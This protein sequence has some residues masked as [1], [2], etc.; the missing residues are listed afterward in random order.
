LEERAT[1]KMEI[2][3]MKPCIIIFIVSVSC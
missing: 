2:T 3:M 1:T